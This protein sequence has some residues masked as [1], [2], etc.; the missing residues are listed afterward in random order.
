MGEKEYTLYLNSNFTQKREQHTARK[1]GKG[2]MK[3]VHKLLFELVNKCLMLRSERR[4]EVTYL[5]ITVMEFLDQNRPVN[6]PSLMNKH[7]ARATNQE[8]GYSCSAILFF[9]TR[10][11]EHFKV[12]LRAPKKGT[13]KDML[14]RKP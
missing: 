7:M 12:P 1:L 5:D 10:I 3:P 14:M 4:N 13:K 2:E 8:K 11:F 9:F 6:L